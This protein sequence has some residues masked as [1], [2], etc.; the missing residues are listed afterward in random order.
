MLDVKL[1]P[2]LLTTSL[3]VQAQVPPSFSLSLTCFTLVA[4]PHRASNRVIVDSCSR[5]NLIPLYSSPNCDRNVIY[6]H[7]ACGM[8]DNDD[9]DDDDDNDDDDKEERVEEEEKGKDDGCI[10]DLVYPLRNAL[11]SI[12]MSGQQSPTCDPNKASLCSKFAASLAGRPIPLPFVDTDPESRSRS[13]NVSIRDVESKNT[14]PICASPWTAPCFPGNFIIASKASRMTVR[15]LFT[16]IR[17]FLIS[18]GYNPSLSMISLDWRSNS[19]SVISVRSV[20]LPRRFARRSIAWDG[21]EETAVV[22]EEVVVEEEEEEVVVMGVV[23]EEGT[24]SLV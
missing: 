23:I 7:A 21:S 17:C 2:A 1:A 22:V 19:A 3:L 13:I 14:L 4:S 16:L 15:R 11:I 8:D 18:S 10:D 12:S 24:D 6:V 5:L 20:T 9:D